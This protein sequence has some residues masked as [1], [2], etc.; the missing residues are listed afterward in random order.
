MRPRQAPAFV[1]VFVLL[2][3]MLATAGV[4]RPRAARAQT[5]AP[6][7]AALVPADASIY[8]AVT[9]DPVSPQ[10]TAADGLLRQ[11]GFGNVVDEFFG[12]LSEIPGYQAGTPLP[13]GELGFAV[14]DVL[15]AT[16][17][18]ENGSTGGVVG[19][20]SVPGKTDEIMAE[21]ERSLAEYAADSGG[22]VE[23]TTYNGVTILS[24]EDYEASAA[25]GDFALFGD[26]PQDLYPAID[27]HAG[28]ATPITENADFA[29]LRSDLPANA[30]AYA[31]LDGEALRVPLQR[32]MLEDPDAAP[33][34]AAALPQINHR[35]GAALSVNEAGVQ[36]DLRLAPGTGIAAPADQVAPDLQLD[37]QVG[38]ETL[39]FV[40]GVDLGESVGFETM[41]LLVAQGVGSLLFGQ[42]GIAPL[43]PAQ[44]FE[45]AA[46]VLTFDLRDDFAWRL[47]GEYALAVSANSLDAGGID[48][49]LVSGVDDPVAVADA[50]SK[51]AVLL[52]AATFD[53]G[54]GTGP[55]PGTR[56]VDGGLIQVLDLPVDEDGTLLHL[57]FGV[58]GQRFLLGYRSGLSDFLAGPDET[59]AGTPRYREAMA[60]LPA[61]RDWQLYVDLGRLIPLAQ[62]ADEAF[63]TDT[64]SLNLESV[65]SLAAV[66]FTR[67]GLRG[68]TMVLSI[69]AAGGAVEGTPV[70]SPEVG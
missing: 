53:N 24:V 18:A 52:N 26:R 15:A 35:F 4:A 42:E 6:V 54:N 43:E 23:R 20:F 69:P 1:A 5:A 44:Y 56:A 48:G 41:A 49:V 55:V 65:E 34:I 30:L 28:D 21:E 39:L 57:E 46:R 66:G 19:I 2:I 16:G 10:I 13:G 51:L 38:A 37:Q 61:E 31:Y 9:I 63:A 47:T 17:D 50:T 70:A 58:A 33:F 3:G 8:V 64:A 60:A 68:M 67:D 59:L 14:T 62:Q 7:T 36:L 25:I 12:G 45:A 32:T 11:L 29:K 27:V 22:T 40:N